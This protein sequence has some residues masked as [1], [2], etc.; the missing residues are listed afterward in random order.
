MA[1]LPVPR[2][3]L[4]EKVGIPGGPIR[5]FF[6][7]PSSPTL[8]AMKHILF[9]AIALVA[10]TTANAQTVYPAHAVIRPIPLP[11]PEYD[12]PY[13]GIV[14][15]T[16]AKSLEHVRELCPIPNAKYGCAFRYGTGCLIVLAPDADIVAVGW[17]TEL[18]KR[19]EIGHCNGWPA[20]HPN[21]R[22]TFDAQFLG[23]EPR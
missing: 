6:L 9:A 8:L 2:S 5:V 22:T 3:F 23:L 16:V 21:A 7:P 12:H 18:A 1:P 11:P 17:T 13:S 4:Q 20:N 15:T 14:V 10:A 19:H